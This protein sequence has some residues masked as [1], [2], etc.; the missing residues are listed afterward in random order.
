MDLDVW[1]FVL[2]T[3]LLAMAFFVGGQLFLVVAVVPVLSRDPD[4]TRI[5]GVARRFGWGS[6]VAVL[7]AAA[8]G[9]LMASHFELWEQDELQLKLGLVVLA[10]ALVAI[11]IK[12]PGDHLLEGLIFLDSLAIVLVATTL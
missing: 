7:V 5:R 3:H 9:A 11:H 8:T 6:L 12:R 4:R 2:W 10:A 1:N